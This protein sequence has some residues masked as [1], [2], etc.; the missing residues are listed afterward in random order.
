MN[1][2]SVTRPGQSHSSVR[3]GVAGKSQM[4]VPFTE[5]AENAEKIRIYPVVAAA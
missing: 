2:E 3:G 1:G 5:A 4:F